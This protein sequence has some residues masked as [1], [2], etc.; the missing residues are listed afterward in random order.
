MSLFVTMPNG[1]SIAYLPSDDEVFLLQPGFSQVQISREFIA[2]GLLQPIA[3]E[4]ALVLCCGT[5]S[6][7]LSVQIC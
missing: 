5:T 6:M 4:L 2:I 7:E 1:A 3:L